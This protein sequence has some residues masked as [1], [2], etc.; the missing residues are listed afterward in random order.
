MFGRRRL[1]LRERPRPRSAPDDVDG[2]TVPY[3][4][5]TEIH[6]IDMATWRESGSYYD[7]TTGQI[8]ADALSLIA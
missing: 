7:L 5:A 6:G 8:T 3:E 1:R 2:T 4:D